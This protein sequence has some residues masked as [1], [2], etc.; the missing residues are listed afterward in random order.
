M[1]AFY[2]GFKNAN[3]K[4]AAVVAEKKK[5]AE[6]IY[7]MKQDVNVGYFT[8]AV[9]S[10]TEKNEIGTSFYSKKPSGVYKIILL[11]ALNNDKESRYLDSGMFKMKDS[12]GRVYDV[13]SEAGTAL[14]MQMSSAN[15]S[16]SINDLFL[17]QLNP[18]LSTV[19]FLVFD[20]PKDATGLKLEVSGGML[21]SEK[22]YIEL[23]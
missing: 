16:T 19:G 4:T 22:K 14:N 10:M 5:S 13:S 8:Y 9:N 12:Q 6:T 15:K 3:E 23:Q 11:A 7:K 2:N 20:I 1:T 18:S 21:S 17:K